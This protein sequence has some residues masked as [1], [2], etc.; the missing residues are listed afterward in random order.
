MEENVTL[1]LKSCSLQEGVV[2]RAAMQTAV[3]A[4]LAATLAGSLAT[5]ASAQSSTPVQGGTL[6]LGVGRPL[7]D[8]DP[9]QGANQ[10][11]IIARTLYSNLI[12][13]SADLKPVP[14]LAT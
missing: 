1:K 14:D 13:Y 7:Q 10:N 3:A 9:Y 11:Y 8:F 5:G 6:T 4:I 2:R 12:S